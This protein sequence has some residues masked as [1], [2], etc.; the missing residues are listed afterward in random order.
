MPTNKAFHRRIQILDQ[1]LRRRQKVWTVNAL[2][3]ATNAH[4]A[5]HGYPEISIRTLYD[6]LRYL[7]D[8]LTAPV[9]KYQQGK[10]VCY[11]YSD[12]AYTLVNSPLSEE[13]KAVLRKMLEYLKVNG[14]PMQDEITTLLHRHGIVAETDQARPSVRLKKAESINKES[15]EVLS[16]NAD[17]KA[18]PSPAPSSIQYHSSGDILLNKLVLRMELDEFSGFRNGFWSWLESGE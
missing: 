16:S 8:T 15:S 18:R 11:R 14:L 6:D 7:Q 2:L 17:A 9:E 1:C 4:L 10:Q 12:P 3:E 13:E 5:D